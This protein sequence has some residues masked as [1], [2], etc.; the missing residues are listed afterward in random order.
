[1][2]RY[3]M[4]KT[5]NKYDRK[6]EVG[7]D[8]IKIGILP[9][10]ICLLIAFLV[11]LYIS[12]STLPDEDPVTSDTAVTEDAAGGVGDPAEDSEFVTDTP[13]PADMRAIPAGWVC[14]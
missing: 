8:E 1:M 7:L 3:K 2:P 10:V 4:T 12:G 6:I 13:R 5:G 11:W 9:L 14:L